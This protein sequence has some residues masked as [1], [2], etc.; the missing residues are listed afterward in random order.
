MNAQNPEPTAQE[1]QNAIL[2]NNHTDHKHQQNLTEIKEKPDCLNSFLTSNPEILNELLENYTIN[3]SRKINFINPS[4]HYQYVYDRKTTTKKALDNEILKF[5][6]DL[7]FIDA[8]D[9]EKI[10]LFMVSNYLIQR[11]FKPSFKLLLKDYKFQSLTSIND[12]YLWITSRG[13]KPKPIFKEDQEIIINDPDLK[14]CCV[15]LEEYSEHQKINCSNCFN[16]EMCRNCFNHLNPKKCPICRS[17]NFT[18]TEDNNQPTQREIKFKYNNQN[19]TKNL[20]FNDYDNT[21]II[22]IYAGYAEKNGEPQQ[23]IFKSFYI[24][25]YEELINDFFED[26]GDRIFY[27]NANF[28]YDNILPQYSEIMDFN[29]F[30]CVVNASHEK[31]NGESIM[32]LLGLIESNITDENDLEQNRKDFFECLENTDGIK[33]T[34]NKEFLEYMG[35]NA[36]ENKKYF[37][38][39]NNNYISEYDIKPEYFKDEFNDNKLLIS[40]TTR[41]DLFD[42]WI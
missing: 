37:M 29:L 34:L 11:K 24:N 25:E 26:L 1:M 30:D 4:L 22:L 12:L 2:G 16:I 28:L 40:N 6:I 27:F 42:W 7:L 35:R 23:V 15:C 3:R 21:E 20:N 13:K 18:K 41:N 8:D 17:L 19:L 14:N 33:H 32:K 10:K 36:T 5:V 39:S 31:Q 38:H 9:D